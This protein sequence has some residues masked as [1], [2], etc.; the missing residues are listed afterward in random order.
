VSRETTEA[1]IAANVAAEGWKAHRQDCPECGRAVR[2]RKWHE[3]CVRGAILRKES[4][5][6]DRQLAVERRLD[7]LPSPDQPP[8]F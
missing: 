2:T 3:V 8:L 1:R 7:R 5:D 6:A 4:Q